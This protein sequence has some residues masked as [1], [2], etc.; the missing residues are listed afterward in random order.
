IDKNG[1]PCLLDPRSPTTFSDEG[2]PFLSRFSP[3]KS[4][5][6]YFNQMFALKDDEQ[7][8][9]NWQNRNIRRDLPSKR[10]GCGA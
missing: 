10:Q 8:Q 4:A 5:H 3:R 7:L 9:G 1:Q 6:S 2:C